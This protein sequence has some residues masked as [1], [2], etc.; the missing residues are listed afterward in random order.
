MLILSVFRIRDE[1]SDHR[2]CGVITEIKEK[3]MRG[4]FQEGVP[5]SL[6]DF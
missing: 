6:F 4:T 5:L 1:T 3:K 2:K